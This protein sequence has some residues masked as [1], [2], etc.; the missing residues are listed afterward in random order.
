MS[1]LF[2]F[3]QFN[4]NF[5]DRASA[6]QNSLASFLFDTKNRCGFERV[7]LYG[8]ELSGKTFLLFEL[9]MSFAD[10]GKHVLYMSPK[11]IS[12]LPLLAHGRTQPT[13]VTLNYIQ[14]VYLETREEYLNYMASRENEGT[15]REAQGVSRDMSC[16]RKLFS[17]ERKSVF[18][19]VRTQSCL[20]LRF[21]VKRENGGARE[22]LTN[23]HIHSNIRS[24]LACMRTPRKTD[25]R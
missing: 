3:E 6:A 1:R 7:M 19:D 23:I 5:T 16:P 12:K 25:F 2:C 9:A 21:L 13:R 11:K 18:R 17:D 8:P 15:E 24:R 10:E 14:V 20:A 4:H 22:R